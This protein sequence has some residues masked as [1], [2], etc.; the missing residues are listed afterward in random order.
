M[1][2]TRM[3]ISLRVMNGIGAVQPS[4]HTTFDQAHEG[5]L[6]LKR[7][8][9]S[10]RRDVRE[11]MHQLS[12]EHAAMSRL[13][14]TIAAVYA[15][16]DPTCGM[17]RSYG[18][19]AEG[20]KYGLVCH[21]IEA[22]RVGVVEPLDAWL[23]EIDAVGESLGPFQEARLRFDHYRRKV[24][25]MSKRMVGEAGTAA[26]DRM[27]ERY[28]RN[29]RKL[30][31]VAKEYRE[32]SEIVCRS[33]VALLQRKYSVMNPIFL[34]LV[35]FQ[36]MYHAELCTQMADLT[37]TFEADMARLGGG[38]L[39]P[40]V[41]SKSAVK[42]WQ[43]YLNKKGQKGLRDRLLFCVLVGGSIWMYERKED[44]VGE[45]PMKVLD[46][47]YVTEWAGKGNCSFGV[48]STEG[49]EVFFW[50]VS[51]GE[52]T[53]WLEALERGRT[54]DAEGCR[55][56]VDAQLTRLREARQEVTRALSA[57]QLLP[58]MFRREESALAPSVLELS[59]FER[60]V[61]LPPELDPQRI[62]AVLEQAMRA[63]GAPTDPK[64]NPNALTL[65]DDIPRASMD[66][67]SGDAAGR[68]M[69]PSIR[70]FLPSIALPRR[71]STTVITSGGLPPVAAGDESPMPASTQRPRQVP[72]RSMAAPLE[73]RST[74][75]S[76]VQLVFAG[77]AGEGA[78][79]A[80]FEQLLLW[81]ELQE[82]LAAG[83]LSSQDVAE[84]YEQTATRHGLTVEGFDL[85]VTLL[86]QRQ[87]DVEDV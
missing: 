40:F 24:E 44:A 83:A 61:E 57:K 30:A 14:S 20:N 1:S 70:R 63:R 12:S 64:I 8:T 22:L 33:L 87:G 71:E 47:A 10:L 7:Q 42:H 17:S 77:I 80:S 3:R 55:R 15:D 82:L 26:N 11:F 25:E 85:F 32:T 34:R 58:L 60:D 43:G 16:G 74:V 23:Q 19:I 49:R 65:P 45:A 38:S 76:D 4:G 21:L 52:R 75:S 59:D 5:F 35:E 78:T 6:A 79:V 46:V 54:W 31:I 28:D 53:G 73:M 68:G 37:S 72:A 67:T 50:T 66:S 36:A 81:P 29:A 2:S 56:Q 9:V 13:A 69:V 84:L 39:E 18:L 62:Q 86:D 48:V 27:L 51:P 41:A